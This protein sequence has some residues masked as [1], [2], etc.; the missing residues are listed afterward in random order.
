MRHEDSREYR[1]KLQELAQG[2]KLSEE[3]EKALRMLLKYC[4]RESYYPANFTL[5]Q[6]ELCQDFLVLLNYRQTLRKRKKNMQY[7]VSREMLIPEAEA[8]TYIKLKEEVVPES[9]EDYNNKFNEYFHTAMSKLA[10]ERLGVTD[11][12][13]FA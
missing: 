1:K 7:V 3:A 5:E 13:T 6:T 2:I 11:S 12:N 9:S 4:D 10:F 8:I